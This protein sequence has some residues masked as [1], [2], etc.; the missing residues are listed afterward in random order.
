M[1]PK[2]RPR[3]SYLGLIVHRLLHFPCMAHPAQPEHPEPQEV[4]PAFLSLYNT[5]MIRPMTAKSPSPTI[6]VPMGHLL[7]DY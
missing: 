6:T 3:G 5:Y 4:F 7:H 1:T 2:H